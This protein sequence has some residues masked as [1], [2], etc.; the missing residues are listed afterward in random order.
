M[1]MPALAFLGLALSIGLGLLVGKLI[2]KDLHT[3]KRF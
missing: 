1:I 3:P 2:D